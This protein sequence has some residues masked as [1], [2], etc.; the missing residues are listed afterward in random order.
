MI[1]VITAWYNEEFLSNLFLSHYIFADKII[2]LLDQ[3]NTDNSIDY[4]SK[5]KNT[6]I[7]KLEMPEGMDDR[8]KQ[9]QINRE[10]RKIDDGWVIIADADEFIYLPKNGINNFLETVK[11]D[12]VKIDY[13]QMYQH[14]TEKPLDSMTPV[15]QQRRYGMRNGFSRWQKPAI[16]R[17]G[18]YI[19][20]E[21][22]H[23]GNNS[24]PH[25]EMLKGA[26]WAM[27]DVNLAINRRIKGR[28]DRMSPENLAIGFSRHNFEITEE[29]IKEI[30]KKYNNC[31]RVFN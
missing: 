18:Q 29:Q 22:G 17:T 12:T 26:H 2:I 11:E 20:W 9:D 15:F 3:N 21:P 13:F 1:T 7:K 31:P 23:H 19:F 6:T 8:L 27:A 28:R 5:F 24:D 16:A 10:Y 25:P 4:I 14:V 30:C